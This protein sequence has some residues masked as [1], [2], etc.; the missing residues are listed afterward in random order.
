MSHIYKFFEE[1]IVAVKKCKN[2]REKIKDSAVLV[3]IFMV[4]Y[5]NFNSLLV[6]FLASCTLISIFMCLQISLNLHI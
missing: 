1:N 2:G 5:S 6:C 4:Y 3:R